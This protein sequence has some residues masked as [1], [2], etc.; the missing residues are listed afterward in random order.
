[1][2]GLRTASRFVALALLLPLTI[3]FGLGWW[4]EPAAR[5]QAVWFVV[6]GGG[7]R[8]VELAPPAF[9]L[10]LVAIGAISAAGLAWGASRATGA[11]R[12]L[13]FAEAVLAAAGLCGLL[14]V[15]AV[16]AG[17]DRLTFWVGGALT[18]LLVS[19]WDVVRLAREGKPSST[20]RIVG[21]A[22]GMSAFLLAGRTL[23]EGPG[24]HSPV[25]DFGALWLAGPGEW[26]LIS[27]GLWAFG[28]FMVLGFGG[29]G[30]TVRMRGL[31]VAVALVAGGLAAFSAPAPHRV[32]ADALSAAGVVAGAPVL[33]LPWIRLV[34]AAGPGRF[35][36]PRHLLT[37]ALPISAW[38]TVCAA[39][40]LTVFLWTVPG[41]LPPSVERLSE[42]PA[43]FALAT[44]ER[45]GVWFA[46]R[47]VGEVGRWGQDGSEQIVGMPAGAPEE[48]GVVGDVAWFSVASENGGGL[49]PVTTN[50]PGRPLPV[51]G[52]WVASWLALPPEALDLADAASDSVLLGCES[53]SVLWQLDPSTRR[54][55]RAISVGVEVEDAAFGQDKDLYVVSLWNGI[56]LQV[57]DWPS[58]EFVG[59]QVLGPFSWSVQGDVS[60]SLIWVPRFFEG[61][62]LGFAEGSLELMQRIR[63]PF[64][65][66]AAR[67]D[68]E[69]Q[70]LWVSG[71]YAGELVA[72]D[73]AEPSRRT[74]W[75]LCGQGRSLVLEPDGRALVATDCG[76]FRVTAD[77]STSQTN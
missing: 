39:R 51:P 38:A 36:D 64:G 69:H 23:L 61:Q 75:A 65:A 37:W 76:V 49:V 26:P 2:S 8:L 5:I 21:A 58:G 13:S 70:R 40:G 57:L 20:G 66:R 10:P 32:I 74:R 45:G 46:D 18:T 14:G 44:D 41:D 77:P 43:I 3:A 53:S 73:L 50:G 55:D 67:I 6:L 4:N 60:R 9:F 34:V 47:E 63:L 11:W 48:V 62:A 33:L 27:G 29:R 19:R 15:V 1:M 71:A 16:G 31:I 22:M 7:A 12:A 30:L 54:L 42:R 72:I 28:G 24:M 25:F 56:H 59:R 52:C 35:L 68:A 17:V